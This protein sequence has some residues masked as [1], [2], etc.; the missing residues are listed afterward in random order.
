MIEHEVVDQHAMIDRAVQAV[1]ALKEL[2]KP[3]KLGGHCI[4]VALQKLQHLRAT[5]QDLA[6]REVGAAACERGC[7]EN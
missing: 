5:T 1:E 6:M 7:V 3:P 2:P 4:A